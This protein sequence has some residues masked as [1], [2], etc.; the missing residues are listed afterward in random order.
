[1]FP[2]LFIALNL[3][4]I[5]L[6]DAYNSLTQGTPTDNHNPNSDI[7]IFNP[8]EIKSVQRHQSALDLTNG[9]ASLIIE[10]CMA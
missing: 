7:K 5:N 4:K 2:H 8:I 10:S 1:M 9:P 6:A 3:C